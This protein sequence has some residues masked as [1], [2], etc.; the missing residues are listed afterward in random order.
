MNRAKMICTVLGLLMAVTLLA[1]QDET[2]KKKALE[3]G[4]TETLK[5]VKKK[6]PKRKGHM[7]GGAIPNFSYP[8]LSAHIDL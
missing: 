5:E 2:N 1:Q 3:E 8:A 6:S 7:Q 4:K